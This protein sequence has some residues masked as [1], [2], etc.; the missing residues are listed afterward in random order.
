MK[1][2]QHYTPPKGNKELTIEGIVIQSPPS[3]KQ[4]AIAVCGMFECIAKITQLIIYLQ[5]QVHINKGFSKETLPT[6]ANLIYSEFGF[7]SFEDIIL[8]FRWGLIG[9][10]G[11]IYDRLDISVLSGWLN[12]YVALK[13]DRYGNIKGTFDTASKKVKE[14]PPVPLTEEEKAEI[15]KIQ[16]KIYEKIEEA[17]KKFTDSGSSKMVDRKPL[18]QEEFDQ[19]AFDIFDGLHKAQNYPTNNLKQRVCKYE[20]KNYTQEEFIKLSYQELNQEQTKNE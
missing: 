18:P 11:P 15:K 19:M 3:I 14:L 6:A 16:A 5:K 13:R 2:I 7:L 1:S 8:C 4:F 20:G 17:R 9:K 12:S 10:W